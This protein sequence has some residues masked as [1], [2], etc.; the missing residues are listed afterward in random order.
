[1]IATEEYQMKLARAIF[2]G[3]KEYQTHTVQFARNTKSASPRMNLRPDS[4]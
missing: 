2:N 3:I 4:E 1:L